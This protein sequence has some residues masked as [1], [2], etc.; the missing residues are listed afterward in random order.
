M[1]I[2]SLVMSSLVNDAHQ[3]R[4]MLAGCFHLR[5]GISWR[6]SC[7]WSFAVDVGTGYR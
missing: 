1:E 3:L 4:M 5:S 2:D 6:N 7:A